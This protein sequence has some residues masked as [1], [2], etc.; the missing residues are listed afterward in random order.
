LINL[1][2][3]SLTLILTGI[4]AVILVVVGLMLGLL[5]R[6]GAASSPE[7]TPTL[8]ESTSTTAPTGT[9]E[10]SA[11]PGPTLTAVPT[12]TATPTLVPTLSLAE[13]YQ[14]A[15]ASVVL[16][17]GQATGLDSFVVSCPAGTN[18]LSGGFLVVDG[19]F[20]VRWRASYPLNDHTWSVMAVNTGASSRRILAYAICAHAPPGYE[21]ASANT[22][23]GTG[24]AT[25]A[26][27]LMAGCPLGKRALGG[28]FLILDGTFDVQ[29]WANAPSDPQTWVV[30]AYNPATAA[31]RIAAF[32]TCADE[33]PG[34]EVTTGDLTLSAAL[35]PGEYLVAV[36]PTGKK[37]LGGGFIGLDGAADLLWRASQAL[38]R[39]TWGM[40]AGNSSFQP[41]RLEA[42]AVCA[43]DTFFQ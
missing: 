41:R 16:A 38:D 8:A 30:M 40:I 2:E 15:S 17:P 3:R 5:L 11:T 20:D 6:P 27:G 32:V 14:V 28:G 42:R 29:W 13:A 33:P 25:G 37:L 10:P 21:I 31:R 12:L 24:Q 39:Q 1:D 7:P 35:R 34:Y 22:T 23:L 43:A 18:V 9:P 26:N 36:C 4:V 19:A